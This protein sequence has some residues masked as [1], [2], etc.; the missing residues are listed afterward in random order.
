MPRH[1]TPSSHDTRVENDHA[2]G[3][4]QQGEEET[5]VIN[6]RNRW[7]IDLV[8]MHVFSWFFDSSK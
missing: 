1:E 8:S 3:N 5:G 6:E 2:V 7:I 4:D